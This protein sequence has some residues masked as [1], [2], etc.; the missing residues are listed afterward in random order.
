MEAEIV[1]WAVIISAFLSYKPLWMYTDGYSWT[2]D[3]RWRLLCL[4]M[5][6]LIL[7]LC[8]CGTSFT[9]LFV[10]FVC[11]LVFFLGVCLFDLGDFMGGVAIFPSYL[12]KE[13]F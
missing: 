9:F 13:S 6:A 3:I 12:S 8:S 2:H 1:L 7:P 5:I 11:L 4:N 10:S